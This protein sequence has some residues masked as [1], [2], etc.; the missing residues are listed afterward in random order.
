MVDDVSTWQ[1]PVSV[2]VPT[3]WRRYE[4]L[5]EMP[6]GKKPK[7]II[8]DLT[9]DIFEDVLEIMSV[10]FCKDEVMFGCLKITEDPVSL[11]ELQDLWRKLSK[12]NAGLVALLDDGSDRPRVAGANMTFVCRKQ[13]KFS[14]DDF[15]GKAMKAM[16]RDGM[17][18][19]CGYVNIFQHYGVKEYLSAFGLI[20]HPDFRGQGLGTEILK[21]RKDLCKALGLKVT[22]T[23]FTTVEGQK[24]AKKAGM[25]VLAEIPYE[26]FK[27][28]DGEE[29]YPIINP[30][31]AKVMAMRI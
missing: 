9:E 8:Q 5:L 11:T 18:Y 29:V 30:K 20:V 7:F 1:R 10:N 26:I 25:D 23:F 3:V 28:E 31:T 16:A 24:S 12:Q 27:T 2:P 21:A 6:D 13:D 4:G 15:K 22:M 19:I 17:V 14:P